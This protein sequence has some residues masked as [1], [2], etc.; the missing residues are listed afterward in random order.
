MVVYDVSSIVSKNRSVSDGKLLPTCNMYMYSTKK[1]CD[2]CV[3][4]SLACT[5]MCLKECVLMYMYMCVFTWVCLWMCLC[6]C[7]FV[8]VCVVCVSWCVQAFYSRPS[9]CLQSGYGGHARPNRNNSQL[10]KPGLVNKSALLSVS[11]QT[12]DETRQKCPLSPHYNSA[13]ALKQDKRSL[14]L[15][16]SLLDP[17]GGQVIK[18]KSLWSKCFLFVLRYLTHSLIAQM[19][20]WHAAEVSDV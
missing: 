13:A 18:D 12:V 3:R 1:L 4:V 10:Y 7:V 2:F 11:R 6:V 17:F 8:Y 20:A 19:D 16:N 15:R 5:T 9:V 14:P